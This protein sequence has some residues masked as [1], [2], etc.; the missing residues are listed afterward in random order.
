[1]NEQ[2]NIDIVKQAYDA[3]QRGDIPAVLDRL[4]PDI[5]WEAGVGLG[6]K[7]PIGGRRRGL[8]QVARFFTTLNEN[9]TFE[10]FEPRE[11]IA[12]GDRVVVLGYY[13]ATVKHTRR[14]MSSEWAMV[15]T[16]R[17][18]KVT[19]FR[20][21]TDTSAALSAYGVPVHA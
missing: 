11:Y 8:D 4:S 18:G 14:P 17:N 10:Q 21:F 20:E 13:K 3:F 1:M 7:V 15:F 19:Q 2:K 9:Q 6:D 12:Q 16:V 5:D